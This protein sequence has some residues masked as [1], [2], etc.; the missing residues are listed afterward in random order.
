MTASFKQKKKKQL[1]VKLR[2]R[3]NQEQD[4]DQE[5]RNNVIS[6]TDQSGR[7]MRIRRAPKRSY[8]LRSPPKTNRWSNKIE[9]WIFSPI[10]LSDC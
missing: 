9:M 7:G 3:Q 8:Q 6:I 1:I 4:Q 10:G 2:V 5:Q